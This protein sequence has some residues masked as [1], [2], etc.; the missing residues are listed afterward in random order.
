MLFRSVQRKAMHKFTPDEAERFDGA[1]L[2]GELAQAFGEPFSELAFAQHVTVWQKNEAAHGALLDAALRYAAWAALSIAGRKR[3]RA[4]VL[5]K[6]PAKLDYQQ[7]VPV[8]TDKSGGYKVHHLGREH[9]RRRE[10]FKLTDSG[11]DL[12]G[13]LDE[14][15]YC[16]WCHEQEIGRASCRERV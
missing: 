6:A 3:H 13:A 2:E 5:F 1:A 12:T 16:I 15:H 8:V 7:L 14:A 11:T 10:G 9:L 4:G